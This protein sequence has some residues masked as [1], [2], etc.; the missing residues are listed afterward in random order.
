MALCSRAH[1]SGTDVCVCMF[2]CVWVRVCGSEWEMLNT[3]F[4]CV[5]LWIWWFGVG[6]T[7]VC[8]CLNWSLTLL[9]FILVYQMNKDTFISN[10][11]TNRYPVMLTFCIDLKYACVVSCFLWYVQ[12][13]GRLFLCWWKLRAVEATHKCTFEV[14][15]QSERHLEHASFSIITQQELVWQPAC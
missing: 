6:P 9:H 7:R 13:S 14:S 15:G 10:V 4:V 12:G 2:A 5:Y 8:T 3:C 1:P 11:V